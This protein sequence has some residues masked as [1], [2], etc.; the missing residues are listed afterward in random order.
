MKKFL[1]E[2]KEFITKGNILDL[3]VGVI[4]G[5]AFR[6]IVTSLVNDLI[7]PLISAV[8]GSDVKDWVWMIK[9]AVFGDGNGDGITLPGEVLKEPVFLRYGNFI[10]TIIDFLLV[11]LVLFI[12]I[13]AAM[14]AAEVREKMKAKL[15]KEAAEAAPVVEE[16]PAVP[17]NAEEVALLKEIVEL[18][19]KD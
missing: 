7:M 16:V 2:F 14:K 1:Q 5:G 15:A 12:I 10:Q 11:A 18:L 4:I 17:A 3:A 6:A 13:K 19:K 9:P 8:V